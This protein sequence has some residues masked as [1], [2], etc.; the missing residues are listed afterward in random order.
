MA[1]LAFAALLLGGF[2]LNSILSLAQR[3]SGRRRRFLVDALKQDGLD[4]ATR[5]FLL[6]ELNALLVQRATGIVGNQVYRS[7]VLA[8]IARSSGELRA[9]QFARAGRFLQLR[10]GSRIDVVIRRSDTFEYWATILYGLFLLVLALGLFSLPKLAPPIGNPIAVAGLIALGVATLAFGCFMFAQTMPY[11]VAKRIAP[12]LQR[13][14]SPA[15]HDIAVEPGE[16]RPGEAGLPCLA[17]ARASL[18]A[19]SMA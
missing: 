14:Q 19:R 4:A 15:R 1:T 2:K 12:V 9:G 11:T 7:T 17:S 16:S 8:L 10:D 3:I 5:A 18:A 6:E 13:L